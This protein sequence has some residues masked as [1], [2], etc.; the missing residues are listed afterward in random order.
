MKA[1]TPQEAV[2]EQTIRKPYSFAEAANKDTPRFVAMFGDGGYFTRPPRAIPEHRR[3]RFGAIQRRRDASGRIASKSR[4]RNAGLSLR[5][6]KA[7]HLKGRLRWTY[8][9]Y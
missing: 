7:A 1:K 9:P 6:G 5:K 2:N 8:P 3:Q 4:I